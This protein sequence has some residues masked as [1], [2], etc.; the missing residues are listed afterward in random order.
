MNNKFSAHEVPSILKGATLMAS[1]GGGKYTLGIDILNN[2]LKREHS[3]TIFE[4]KDASSFKKTDSGMSIAIMGSPTNTG[5]AK[6]LERVAISAYNSGRKIAELTHTELNFLMSLELGGAN[7]VIPII[8]SLEYSIPLIDA[9]LCG[10]AV[11]E[12]DTMLSSLHKLPVAPLSITD[13]D[14]NVCGIYLE[15]S[16][17]AKQAECTCVGIINN[18][19]HKKGG[20]GGI[21]GWYLKAIQV[22]SNVATGTI[23]ACFKI[24]GLLDSLSKKSPE[25]R[26]VHSIYEEIRKDSSLNMKVKRLTR[27]AYPVNYITK[28]PAKGGALDKGTISIGEGANRYE[29]LYLNESLVLNKVY[30][31]GTI[32]TIATAPDIITM[33]DVTTGEPVTNADIYDWSMKGPSE[34]GK[35]KLLLGLIK[36]HDNWDVSET[37]LNA[38]WKEAFSLTGYS[39]NVVR[40]PFLH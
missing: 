16:S 12:L 35:H 33:Y 27:I 5:G 31:D 19:S 30:R 40:Y 26:E 8:N 23:T 14:M 25:E 28:E 9:D 1:G 15:D 6:E 13:Q 39:G 34:L 38:F 3:K 18:A 24:G 7:T 22:D 20:C 21:T 29:I 37:Q 10:R 32:Q 4:V 11:P 36:A 17:D 2:Y